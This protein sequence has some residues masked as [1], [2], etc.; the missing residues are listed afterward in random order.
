MTLQTKHVQPPVTPHVPMPS[1]PAPI[2]LPS[3]PHTEPP[4]GLGGGVLHQSAEEATTKPQVEAPAKLGPTLDRQ[5][6][7]LSPADAGDKGGILGPRFAVATKAA[8]KLDEGVPP[9]GLGGGQ[10]R[11]SSETATMKPSGEAATV[12]LGSMFEG[13]APPPTDR[14]DPPLQVAPPA[15]L[16]EQPKPLA[17]VGHG[18]AAQHA[19]VAAR[20][21]SIMDR[22][23]PGAM[24]DGLPPLPTHR[25]DQH[26]PIPPPAEPMEQPKPYTGL[27][28]GVP[29]SPRVN[30]VQPPGLEDTLQDEVGGPT[31]LEVAL[32]FTKEHATGHIV[33]LD[34][35]SM[36]RSFMWLL[37]HRQRVLQKHGLQENAVLDW[38]L[39]EAQKNIANEIRSLLRIMTFTDDDGVEHSKITLAKL[40]WDPNHSEM[41]ELPRANP[42]SKVISTWKKG[43]LTRHFGQESFAHAILQCGINE[44][45]VKLY[46]EER[47][48]EHASQE[49]IG[50][51][52]SGVASVSGHTPGKPAGQLRHEL[53]KQLRK[54][55]Y[56]LE[57]NRWWY[58]ETRIAQEEQKL[59]DLERQVDHLTETV[60]KGHMSNQTSLATGGAQGIAA[61][62]AMRL[63][64]GS[65]V[66]GP[67]QRKSCLKCSGIAR[68]R[69][70]PCQGQQSTR[71]SD[72]L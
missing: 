9:T 63:K 28:G 36:V 6:W 15:G 49:V 56:D 58:D 52:A 71:Y 33:L 45:V 54:L 18:V 10:L 37:G 7:Q 1:R 35:W 16:R 30:Q 32:G 23:K 43:T 14:Q 4:T 39:G 12:K 42:T 46:R 72:T 38:R 8:S 48:R 25:P 22:P 17:G 66:L 44:T 51:L 40:P 65:Q 57:G 27:G 19:E 50:T 47:D 29:G 5:D 55:K 41:E 70:K 13:L 34:S 31:E 67:P 59:A 24:S 3:Q 11:P 2:N 53:Q 21:S 68:R 26:L 20:P 62:V 60:G 61:R 69:N 64:K